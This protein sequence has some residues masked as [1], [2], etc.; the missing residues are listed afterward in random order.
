MTD[1]KT[2]EAADN[3]YLFDH[4]S[5]KI[6]MGDMRFSRSACRPGQTIPDIKVT[7]DKGRTTTL[8]EMAKDKPLMLV[9]GSI[10][11]PMTISSLPLLNDLQAN[12]GDKINIVLVYVRE[13]HP[14]EHYPQPCDMDGKHRH[15]QD[16]KEKYVLNFPVIVDGLDGP[17]HKMLDVKPN[18]VHIMDAEGK[19]LLQSLWA[20]DIKTIQNAVEQ[21]TNHSPI[22]DKLSEV[23]FL[24]FVRGAGFMHDT[25]SL[26]GKRAYKELLYGAPPIWV[27][28]RLATLF[29]FIPRPKRGGLAAV[30]LIGMFCLVLY[31][32]Q[33]LSLG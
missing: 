21:I 9:T 19:I 22:K 24:P 3:R 31:G 7:T 2:C 4:F 25:L 26:A 10:T 30:L 12:S 5:L 28:S 15:A 1:K 29:T 27:I 6:M 20:G 16:L 14:G 8:Y 23:M 17:L 33:G 13:A 18:S 32:F 11:C